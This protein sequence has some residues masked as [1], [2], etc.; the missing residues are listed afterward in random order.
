MLSN[1]EFVLAMLVR[2]REV[3]ASSLLPA[4][5]RSKRGK[6]K[7]RHLGQANL[8][9]NLGEQWSQVVLRTVDKEL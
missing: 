8:S 2:A 5:L 3:E 1:E 6:G 4:R 7:S 9:G